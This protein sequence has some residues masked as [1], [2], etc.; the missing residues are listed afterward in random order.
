MGSPVSLARPP[1]EPSSITGAP[2]GIMS[3]ASA[4]VAPW[5][6]DKSDGEEAEAWSLSADV[7]CG[8][9]SH[10]AKARARKA[11]EGRV[12]KSELENFERMRSFHGAS[13]TRGESYGSGPLRR[14]GDPTVAGPPGGSGKIDRSVG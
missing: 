8:R 9:K 2:M 14:P 5:A 7:D 12:A 3:A 13:P 1:L 6:S 4:R 10:P 11:I